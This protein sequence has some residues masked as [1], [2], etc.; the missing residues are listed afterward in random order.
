MERF[1]DY[2]DIAWAYDQHWSYFPLRAMPM[3]EKY[4]LSD[5]PD[6]AAILDLCCGT[7]QL[8]AHLD[9]RGYR[10]IGLDGSEE[11]LRLAHEN[12]PNVQFEV[13]DAR[14]F[15]LA[16]RF[17]AVVSTYNS[18]NHIMK[19]RELA[20]V[21]RNAAAVLKEGGLFFF[22][23][24]M[25]EAYLEHWDGSFS[26]IDEDNVCAGQASH[27]A[28]QR[29][30]WTEIA[31]FRR[32]EVWH[33]KDVVLQQTWYRPEQVV[34]HLNRSGFTSVQAFDR[35]PTNNEAFGDFSGRSFFLARRK[36]GR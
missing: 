24:N 10:V 2:D 20:R 19:V 5:L 28:A 35:P 23:L 27:N 11:M 31:V 13:D 8:A 9:A 12:A 30:G 26:F 15:Q 34:Y 4:V 33:R 32:D 7:G 29:I 25:E 3:M 6:E 21:F 18:L 17:D 14:S 1:S 16:D 22:D 36:S